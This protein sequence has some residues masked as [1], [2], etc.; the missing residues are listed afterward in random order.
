M[1]KLSC[2]TS[3]LEKQL[4]ELVNKLEKAAESTVK[5]GCERI[6]AQAKE[7]CPV[8]D[9]DLKESINTRYE[10][11]SFEHEGYVYADVPYATYVELGTR[12]RAPKPYMYP[13]YKQNEEFF[14]QRLVELINKEVK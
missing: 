11:K 4:M 12:N 13:A 8:D 9:G 5:E 3:K 14:K 1:I 7:L 2:D 6:E 10:D